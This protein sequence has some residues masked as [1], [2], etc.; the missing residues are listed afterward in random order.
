[1]TPENPASLGDM[2][3]LA[4]DLLLLLLDDEKGTITS[5]SYPQTVLGGALL[6][7]LALDGV[8]E[9]RKEGAWHQAKVHPTGVPMRDE[10]LLVEALATIGE[11]PRTTQDLVNRLG[12]GL[13]AKLGDDLAGRGIVERREQKILGLFPRTLWPTVDSTHEEEVRR[14]LSDVLVHGLSPDQRTA[15]LVSL[16]HAIGRA[17]TVVDRGDV[18]KSTVKARAK[19]IAEGAWAAQAVKDSITAA[20]TA[21]TAAV[22]ATTVTTTGGS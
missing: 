4:E 3:L 19:E 22:V 20:T 1:M 10:P 5:T 16:L 17:E 14:R 18:P 7:E 9:V 12:K 11:R 6:L 2:T 15:A 8:V 21:I 13:A